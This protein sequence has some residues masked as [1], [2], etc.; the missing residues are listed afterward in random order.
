MSKHLKHRRHRSCV[1]GERATEL[2]GIHALEDVGKVAGYG[3]GVGGE[4]EEK[5]RSIEV[6]T[7]L[8]KTEN[9]GEIVTIGKIGKV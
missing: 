4:A 1:D 8:R 3:G 7:T 5:W 2:A 9:D 6:N